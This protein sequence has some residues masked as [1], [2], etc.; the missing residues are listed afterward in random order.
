MNDIVARLRDEIEWHEDGEDFL[1][2]QLVELLKDALAEIEH[3]REA[4]Q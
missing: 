4:T 1:G 3:L 2:R